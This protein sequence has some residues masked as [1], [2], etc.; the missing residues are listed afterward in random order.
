MAY[1]LLCLLMPLDKK[2]KRPKRKRGKCRPWNLPYLAFHE[3][4]EQR[5]KAG[6]EQ[7]QCACCG[8]WRWPDEKPIPSPPGKTMAQIVKERMRDA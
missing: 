7:S 2:P 5:M 8:L 3:D 1:R 4:A 6:Q